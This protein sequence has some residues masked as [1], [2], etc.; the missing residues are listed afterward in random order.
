MWIRCQWHYMGQGSHEAIVD[1][2]CDSAIW[3]HNH[4]VVG[5][6]QICPRLWVI[7]RFWS[8]RRCGSSPRQRVLHGVMPDKI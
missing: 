2:V 7:C 6:F 8:Q 4:K 5:F 1:G 3:D